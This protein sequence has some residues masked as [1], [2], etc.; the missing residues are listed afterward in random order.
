M[1]NMTTILYVMTYRPYPKYEMIGIL[2]VQPYVTLII[3]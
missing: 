3:L 1:D 2:T